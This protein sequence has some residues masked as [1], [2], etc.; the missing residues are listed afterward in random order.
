MCYIQFKVLVSS[1][2]YLDADSSAKLYL[3]PSE[4]NR[5]PLCQ[6]SESS[7]SVAADFKNKR[8]LCLQIV[9]AAFSRKKSSRH[10][11]AVSQ[12]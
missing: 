1:K 8:L 10:L 5:M 7:C 12:V 4:Q 11:R 2:I 9:C 6:D 3:K